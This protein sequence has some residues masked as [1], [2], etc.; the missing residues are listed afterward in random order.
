[1]TYRVVISAEARNA[2]DDHI[3]YIAI[4]KQEPLNATRWLEKALDAVD[5]LAIFPH[6]FPIAPESN[7]SD[8]TIRTPIVDRCSFLYRVDEDNQT[9]FVTR[10]F[11]GGYPRPG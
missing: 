6:R 1:M 11:H 10:F 3:R 9:V 5:A 7:Y 2:L 8:H 4:E